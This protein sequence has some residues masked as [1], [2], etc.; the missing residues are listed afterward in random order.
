[1]TVNGQTYEAKKVFGKMKVIK[2]DYEVH[3]LEK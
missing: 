3:L 1:M 2:K